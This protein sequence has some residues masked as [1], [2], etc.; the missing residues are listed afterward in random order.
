MKLGFASRPDYRPDGRVGPGH[1]TGR[2]MSARS[3]A[4][5]AKRAAQRLEA[6][7]SRSFSNASGCSHCGVWPEPSITC[8]SR[9]PQRR[10]GQAPQII[11]IDDLLLRALHDRQRYLEIA[12]DRGFVLEQ[13]R[14][15]AGAETSPRGAVGLAEVRAEERRD[16]LEVRRERVHEPFLDFGFAGRRR[17]G[18]VRQPL[19]AGKAVRPLAD[20]RRAEDHQSG[21]HRQ[22]RCRLE[23]GMAAEAPA[24]EHRVLQVKLPR[25][26]GDAGGITGRRIILFRMGRGRGIAVAGQVDRDQVIFCAQRSFELLLPNS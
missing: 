14:L 9:A 2:P 13:A 26:A 10:R 6:N 15:R 21:R 25:D 19:E 5:A 3:S 11:E 22:R 7:A 12:H 20:R 18:D 24:D 1:L 17:E 8:T 23:H 16:R 4:P